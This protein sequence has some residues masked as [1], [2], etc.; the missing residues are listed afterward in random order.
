MTRKRIVPVPGLADATPNAYAQCVVAGDLVFVAGQTGVDESYR[1]VSAEF[2]EQARQTLRNVQ[3]ALEAGGSRL[4]DIVT[5]TVHLAD[6]RH[7]REFLAIRKELLGDE[8]AASM[9]VGGAT[10]MQP[11]VLIEVQATGVRSESAQ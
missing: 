2:G 5:M 4:Q 9:V 10:F 7:G 1:L 8:L 11:G 3:L 6:I